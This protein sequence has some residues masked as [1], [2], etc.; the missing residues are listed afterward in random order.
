MSDASEAKQGKY[1]PGSHIPIYSP[2]ILNDAVLDYL[3]IL[4]WNL[5]EEISSQLGFLK[6]KGVKFVTA[7]PN[8]RIF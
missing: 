1:L 7:I 5:S 4:P 2:S 6:N 8:L 3:V